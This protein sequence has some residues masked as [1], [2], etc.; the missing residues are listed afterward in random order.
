SPKPGAVYRADRPSN[1][2]HTHNQSTALLW[3]FLYLRRGA[4]CCFALLSSVLGVWI[5]FKTGKW[6]ETKVRRP[7]PRGHSAGCVERHPP[8][9]ISLPEKLRD[10][11]VAL[12]SETNC[13]RRSASKLSSIC[14]S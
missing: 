3:R 6:P 1:R 4:S 11:G 12:D 13:M 10:F 14:V 2:S 7:K 8:P 5:D 9:V